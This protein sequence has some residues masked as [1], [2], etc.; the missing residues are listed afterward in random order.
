MRDRVK[1]KA[2][3]RIALNGKYGTA[4]GAM[5]LIMAVQWAAGLAVEVLVLGGTSHWPFRTAAPCIWA[6]WR[7]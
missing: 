7:R 1:W 6:I 4:I 5:F 3:A 2:A